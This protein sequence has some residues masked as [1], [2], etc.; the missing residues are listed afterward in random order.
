MQKGPRLSPNTILLREGLIAVFGESIP[1]IGRI[2]QHTFGRNCRLFR[3]RFMTLFPVL[4]RVIYDG[5]HTVVQ[6]NQEE[7]EQQSN[8]FCDVLLR[9]ERH[10]GDDFVGQRDGPVEYERA[11][12]ILFQIARI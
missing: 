4:V 1:T 2:L 3:R 6:R 8:E 5:V 11:V 10:P 9:L 12:S 7:I